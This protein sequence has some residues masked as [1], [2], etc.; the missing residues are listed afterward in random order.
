M[1]KEYLP[2]TKTI[3]FASELIAKTFNEAVKNIFK[4]MNLEINKEEFIILESIYL[5][6]G[7]I[8]FDIA[9]NIVMK[10]SYVC[11]FLAELED[12]GFIRKESTIKGKRQVIIKN[13]ITPNGEKVY[14]KAQKFINDMKNSKMTPEEINEIDKFTESAFMLAAKIKRDFNLKL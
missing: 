14:E 12:K 3:I 8:Q 1:K 9:K 4:E 13:Y 7:I 10:R 2:Y 5:N 11:K 6:P